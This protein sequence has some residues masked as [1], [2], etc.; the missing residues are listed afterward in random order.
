MWGSLVFDG[1]HWWR[2]RALP[3]EVVDTTGAGDS[4]AAGFLSAFARRLPLPEC[5]ESGAAAAAETC[6]HRGGFRQYPV[7]VREGER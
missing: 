1:E 3:V 5:L 6:Q 2:Q 4:F 7:T